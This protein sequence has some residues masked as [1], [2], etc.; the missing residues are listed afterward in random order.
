MTLIQK[1]TLVRAV[2]NVAE[3]GDTDVFPYPFENHV[4]ND[5]SDA[6]VA[7]LD[8]ISKSFREYSNSPINNY[9]TLA[10][11][12]YTGF[13]WATQIDPLWNAYLLSLVLELAPEIEQ[14]RLPVESQQVFSYRYVHDSPDG[15]FNAS[16]WRDFQE[17]T[18]QLATTSNYVVTIDIA[19]FYSR[20][21]H[22]RLENAL[23]RADPGSNCT[24]QIMSIL[25]KLSNNTS[26]GLPVGGPAARLLAELVLDRVDHLIAAEPSLTFCRY[27]DDYRFFVN[28]MQAAYRAIGFVSEKLLRNEGMSLQKSKTRIMTSAEYLSMLDPVN[29]AAGSASKFLGLHIHY[30]PYSPTASDD[31]ERLRDQLNEFDILGLLRDELTKGRVHVA[32]ARRLI[33]ALD[34]MDPEPR[35]QAVQSLMENIETLAP[36]IPQVMLA[37]RS[38]IEKSEDEEV[39]KHVQGKIRELITSGHYL[40]HIDLNLAYMIRA[41]VGKY[42]LENEQLLIRLYSTAHGFGSASSPNIQRDIMLALA[43]WDATYWLSDQ[44]NYVNS[45]HPWVRRAFIIASY[46]LKDEGKHWRDTSKSGLPEFDIIVRDWAASKVASPTWRV[47][48]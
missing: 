36:V 39:V 13:R 44:K 35:G 10:P 38:F 21:Y 2:S 3:R 1:S 46:V 25:G 37:A 33:G 4:M 14:R 6:V 8:K 24:N 47:P 30:D 16:G 11:I 15:I 31:Y 42:S 9:S 48:I 32:L 20:V 41:L 12:G 23:Q 40:A 45:M 26:Y 27:A 22:H 7:L 5:Q 19:D 17:R 18:R 29:P 34:L 43:R 28:D